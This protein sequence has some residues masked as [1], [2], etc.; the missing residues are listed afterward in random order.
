MNDS[1]FLFPVC[2]FSEL[3]FCL[4]RGNI[5]FWEERVNFRLST[6]K[7]VHITNIVTYDFLQLERIHTTNAVCVIL[8]FTTRQ[9]C[10]KSRRNRLF[11]CLTLKRGIIPDVT[12]YLLSVQSVRVDL[13][14]FVT[15]SSG[16]LSRHQT[17][18]AKGTPTW[19]PN[20]G[21]R[22]GRS[23]RTTSR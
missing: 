16:R 9:R 18:P 22:G 2:S 14:S 19:G 20:L 12:D 23:W 8:F 13:T 7:Y 1:Y 21:S 3:K 15:F 5:L 6:E 4:T 11:C 17:S 10:F